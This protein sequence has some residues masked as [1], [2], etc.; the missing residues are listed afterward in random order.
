MATA[1]TIDDLDHAEP[2]SR[3][4]VERFVREKT[5]PGHAAAA[6][7]VTLGEICRR[8]KIDEESAVLLVRTAMAEPDTVH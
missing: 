5:A 1:L 7:A 8:F 3:K 4:L 2:L 6:L